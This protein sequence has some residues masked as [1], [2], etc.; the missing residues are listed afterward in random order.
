M[1]KTTEL[2]PISREAIPRALQKAERYRLL[3]QSWATE[4]ICQDVLEAD[5]SHQQALV[6]EESLRAA[7][8]SFEQAEGLRQPGNDDAILRWNTCVRTLERLRV[9]E[10]SGEPHEPQFGE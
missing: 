10:E 8:R 9:H 5:P 6:M 3:N 4:S 2:K 1:Q 7:M